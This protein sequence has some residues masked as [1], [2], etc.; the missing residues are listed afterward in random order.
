MQWVFW[1]DWNRAHQNLTMMVRYL[2]GSGSAGHQCLELPPWYRSR[3][4]V[5]SCWCLIVRIIFLEGNRII[6]GPWNSKCCILTVDPEWHKRAGIRTFHHPPAFRGADA[7]IIAGFGGILRLYGSSFWLVIFFFESSSSL[8]IGEG[9]YGV[10][11]VFWFFTGLHWSGQH[12]NTDPARLDCCVVK[13]GKE[14]ALASGF[15]R[16]QLGWDQNCFVARKLRPT[17]R[18]EVGFA[19]VVEASLRRFI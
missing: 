11:V 12:T 6:E 16:V 10:L 3:L 18:Q 5:R 15:H 4:P 2:P 14:V 1:M 13:V 9:N 8:P 7:R 19:G 17:M